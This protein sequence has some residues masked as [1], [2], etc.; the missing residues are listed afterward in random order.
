MDINLL[1]K[2][3]V[4]MGAS[5]VHL[6]VGIEPTARIH[7]KFVKLTDFPMTGEM[8]ISCAK[9]VLGESGIKQLETSGEIDT[10]YF[11]EGLSRFRVNVFL[12]RSKCAIAFRVISDNIP[13]METLLLPEV[14]RPLCGR[15]RGLILV[16]GPTGSG[17]STTLASMVAHMNTN[18]AKHIITIEDPIEYLHSHGKSIVNQRQVGTDTRS[19]ANALRAALREDPDVVLVGEMRDLETIATALTAAETGHL[20][21]STL[22][23]VGSAKTIDRI[24]DVFPPEQQHQIRVQLASVIEAVI[25]QQIMIKENGKGRVAAFEVMLGT[26]PIRNLIR[27]GKTHQIQT[28]LQTSAADHMKTMDSSLLELYENRVIG[29]STLLRYCVDEEAVR[30]V[31]R[32]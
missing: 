22:H 32:L 14:I 12:Q 2:R 4:Q 6:S 19:F 24:V 1:L 23:T 25:S 20:V 3:A 15:Q 28:I 7:G 26:P 11:V 21:L 29:T 27:E 9:S 17:K 5:D 30:A 10:A 18:M 16:T 31:A 13:S 8:T